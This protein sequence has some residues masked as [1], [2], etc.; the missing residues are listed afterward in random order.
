MSSPKSLVRLFWLRTPYHPKL[1]NGNDILLLST[2]PSHAI[3]IVMVGLCPNIPPLLLGGSN[4]PLFVLN[5]TC[6]LRRLEH[7][8]IVGFLYVKVVVTI[9]S[10]DNPMEGSST[11]FELLPLDNC[12]RF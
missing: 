9:P 10:Y 4:C 6:E 2:L 12:L 3:C 11:I 8:Q 1:K 5:I 7:V